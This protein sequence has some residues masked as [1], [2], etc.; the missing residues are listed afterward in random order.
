MRRIPGVPLI[1]INKSVVLMEPMTNAT[2][3]HR[4]R[5][6]KS[7]F[8]M[9]LKGQRKPDAGEKRKRDDEEGEKSEKR[10]KKGRN[11]SLDSLFD[12]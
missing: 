9:G 4:E 6:E 11:P 12:E 5:E 3:E 7:K 1:Y 2:E 8:K 10:V